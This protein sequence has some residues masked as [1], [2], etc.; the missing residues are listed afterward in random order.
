MSSFSTTEKLCLLV[1]PI[2]HGPPNR[3]AGFR[4]HEDWLALKTRRLAN[5]THLLK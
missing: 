5:L 2:N 4:S 1:E 3:V